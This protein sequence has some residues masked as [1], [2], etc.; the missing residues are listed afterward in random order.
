MKLFQDKEWTGAVS[1]I[2]AIVV[3]AG[4]GALFGNLTIGA[5]VGFVI[6]LYFI[7]TANRRRQ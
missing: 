1:F 4:I 6:G 2:L 3:G 5:L 7:Y